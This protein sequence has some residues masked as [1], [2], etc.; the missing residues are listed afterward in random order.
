MEDERQAHLQAEHYKRQE[1][2][3]IQ[4][5]KMRAEED[6]IKMAK[7]EETST[8]IPCPVERY[9]DWRSRPFW[10][11][12]PDVVPSN[13]VDVRFLTED[14]MWAAKERDRVVMIK[15]LMEKKCAMQRSLGLWEWRGES[16]ESHRKDGW[17]SVRGS[18]ESY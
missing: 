18:S 17:G 14:Q 10:V 8:G 13:Y 15:R 12:V 3:E 16:D 9:G 11:G 1:K 4:E 5:A 6:R 7:M 2:K